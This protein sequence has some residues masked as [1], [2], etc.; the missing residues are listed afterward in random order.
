MALTEERRERV[1]RLGTDDTVT[2]GDEGRH[3]SHAVLP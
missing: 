2:A 3:A 1:V